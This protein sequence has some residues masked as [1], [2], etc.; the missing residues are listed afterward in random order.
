M[1]KLKLVLVRYLP[2]DPTIASVQQR[3]CLIKD[4]G[5][6]ETIDLEIQTEDVQL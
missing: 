3:L 6:R 1:K 5:S 4:D 2:K